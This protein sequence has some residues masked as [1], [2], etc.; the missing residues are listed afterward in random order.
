MIKN[1]LF[2]MDNTLYRVDETKW[3]KG[4]F[5]ELARVFGGLGFDGRTVAGFIFTHGLNAMINNNGAETNAT[6]F[7]KIMDEKLGVKRAAV[8]PAV[9]KMYS[10]EWEPAL[11][12]I[13]PKPE[14]QEILKTLRGKKVNIILATNPVLPLVATTRR[15]NVA[16]IDPKTFSYISSYENCRF[17]KPN[18]EYYRELIKTCK[19]KP[20]ETFMVGNDPKNDKVIEEL[21]IKCF[22]LTE[23]NVGELKAEVENVGN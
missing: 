4:Y 14:M 7:W 22:L 12:N 11:C 15:L 13:E 19:I 9:I 18:V 5:I 21:G 1:V 6:V 3:N 16:G 20:E 10:T 8:E 23:K 17:S 2:D